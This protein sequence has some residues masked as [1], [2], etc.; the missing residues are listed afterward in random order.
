MERNVWP[1]KAQGDMHGWFVGTAGAELP[2]RRILCEKETL[3]T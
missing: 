1:K 3:R 2:E